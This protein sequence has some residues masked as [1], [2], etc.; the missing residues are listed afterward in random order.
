MPNP[1]RRMMDVLARGTQADLRAQVQFLKAENQ[2]LRAKLP[3]RLQT[4]A[5][6]RDRLVRLGRGLP[7][8]KDIITIVTPKTFTKWVR[9]SI[10]R[11]GKKVKRRR[12]G[13]PKTLEVIRDIILRIAR[14]TDFGYTRL[15]GEL[16]KIGI[17]VSRTTIISILKEANL[18]TGPVRGESPWH[19]FVARHAKTLWACDFMGVKVLTK[20]GFR[21]AYLLVFIHMASRRVVVSPGTL[22]PTS[23]WVCEQAESFARS[24]GV[25]RHAIVLRDRDRK[26]GRKFDGKLAELGCIG[27]MLSRLSPNLNARCERFIQT[28]GK[29]CLDRFIVLGLRHLDHLVSEFTSYYNRER[30]HSALEFRAPAGPA[31]PEPVDHGKITAGDVRCRSRLE[32]FVNVNWRSDGFHWYLRVCA[33][34]LLRSDGEGD[35]SCPVL[36]SGPGPDSGWPRRWA[37]WPSRA[38]TGGAC[39]PTTRWSGSTA[40][41]AGVHGW[42]APSPTG[43]AR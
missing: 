29:E 36:S 11:K 8:L 40:R 6:E 22:N 27:H 18:P 41:C 28:L 5:V 12:P 23:A 35:T 10:K 26:L 33:F 34:E 38:S 17:N 7:G 9:E 16:R 25:A 13:R 15:Q 3:R 24:E 4:T 31:P 37:T 1:F 39:G 30:P 42:W 19:Q 32:Q 14:E 2:V 43:R 21:T 20:T